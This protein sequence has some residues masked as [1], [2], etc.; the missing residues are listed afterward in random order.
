MFPKQVLQLKL[1]WHPMFSN[2]DAGVA[3]GGRVLSEAEV[4]VLDEARG[5][6]F[7]SSIHPPAHGSHGSCRESKRCKR[8]TVVESVIDHREFVTKDEPRLGEG[9]QLRR[10]LRMRPPP[11]AL[12]P[13]SGPRAEKIS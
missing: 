6:A 10:P 3:V 13:K 7:R 9:E 2:L 8:D 12:S 1:E 11:P 4:A 5:V